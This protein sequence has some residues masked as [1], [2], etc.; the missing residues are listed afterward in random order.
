[1]A[2]GDGS[3]KA[4]RAAQAIMERDTP[5]LI[6]DGRW[7]SFTNA[8][9]ERARGADRTAIDG[10]L[11]A[12]GLS[13]AGLFQQNQAEKAAGDQ[14]YTAAKDEARRQ[15]SL[16][17]NAPE[18]QEVDAAITD[19][20]NATGIPRAWLLG[21]A[22]LESGLNPRAVN[23]SSKGLMQ[24]QPRAWKD[25]QD[26]DPSVGAYAQGVFSPKMNALVG[27][28]YLALNRDRIQK[29]GYTG[30]ITPA[31]LYLAHQQGADGFI[32]LWRA[33]EGMPAQT[34]YVTAEKMTRNPPQD[35]GGPTTDKAQFYRRWLAVAERKIGK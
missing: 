1:M 32:E 9:Y 25:V 30:A 3:D 11:R 16:A 6:V 26:I 2:T 22:R 15:R 13:A 24:I 33:S 12:Y 27:A 34:K 28:R 8:A 20:A 5:T 31:V 23:G 18:R 7:G 29:K 17:P 4:V 35:G 19:A 21:F 10:V 14:A